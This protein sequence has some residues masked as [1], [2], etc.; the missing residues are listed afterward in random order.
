MKLS[1]KNLL[2]PVFTIT[3]SIF[4]SLGMECLLNLLG[5]AMA[6]SLDGK[7]VIDQ[8]PRFI[9]FCLGVGFLSLI[10]IIIVLILNI[11]KSEKLGYTKAVWIAQSICSFIISLPM[12]KG[13]E[14]L[15]RYLQEKY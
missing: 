3:Y 15:F 10:A 5:A 14:L 4:L 9:P 7:S 2:I 13:W 6:V 12:I 11:K 1:F 8:Y